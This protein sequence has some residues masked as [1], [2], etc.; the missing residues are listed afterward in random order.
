MAASRRHCFLG[1]K[2]ASLFASIRCAGG[3]PLRQPARRR[4]YTTDEGGCRY[5]VQLSRLH[6]QSNFWFV[7]AV[8]CRLV[9]THRKMVLTKGELSPPLGFAESF[10]D[11]LGVCEMRSKLMLC[12]VLALASAAYAK[13]PKVYQ[14]GSVVQM[15]SVPCRGAGKDAGSVSNKAH[16]TFCQE[17]VLQSERVSHY[18]LSAR[19]E[20]CS[21]SGGR[22]TGAIPAP[23][24]QDDVASGRS[25]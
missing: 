25:R 23:K 1:R 15:D 14:T 20:A 24:R 5:M 12:V 4:R 17:Y 10:N 8:L 3:T 6:P 11:C 2:I 9:P 19:R 18:I 21:A 13:D 7:T 22:G 16:E